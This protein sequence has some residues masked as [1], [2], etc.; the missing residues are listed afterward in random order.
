MA[1]VKVKDTLS[2]VSLIQS[3]HKFQEY[4]TIGVLAF[5]IHYIVKV[6]S[7]VLSGGPLVGNDKL[8][9]DVPDFKRQAYLNQIWDDANLFCERIKQL[10][11]SKLWEDFTESKYGNYYRNIQGIIEHTHYHLGQIILLKKQL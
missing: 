8:S 7:Q 2:D 9:F 11:D 5:H 3:K 1:C 10:D 4:N 6:A